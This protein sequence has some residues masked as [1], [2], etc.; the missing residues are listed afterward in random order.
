MDNG[1]GDPTHLLL[2]PR[3]A[4]FTRSLGKR[5][6]E[7]LRKRTPYCGGFSLSNYSA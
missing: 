7:T 6:H 1:C 3:E 2:P 5:P 4:F